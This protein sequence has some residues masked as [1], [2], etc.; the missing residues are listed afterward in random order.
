MRVDFRQMID[1]RKRPKN[2]LYSA[3]RFFAVV[4]LVVFAVIILFTVILG[5]VRVDGVSMEPTL[6]DGDYLFVNKLADAKRGDIVVVY[7]GRENAEFVIKRVIALGGDQIYAAD[8]VL[9]RKYAGETE[10]SVVDEPYLQGDWLYAGDEKPDT[11]ASESAPLQIPDGEIFYM[12]D[13]RNESYDCRAYGPQP[14]EHVW[15][16]VTGWSMEMKGF[17]TSVFNI[18]GAASA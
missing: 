4:L 8:G 11:F 6:H 1:E 9:Y 14:E 18:F 5:G 3:A 16:V 17:F 15:G 7:T 13:N 2:E 10:F 12:G